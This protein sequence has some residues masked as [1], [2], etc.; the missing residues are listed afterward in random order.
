MMRFY[1]LLQRLFAVLLCACFTLTFARAEVVNIRDDAPQT[2][3]VEKGDTLWDI[4]SLFLD[5]PWRWPELWRNNTQIEN[6][7]LIYPGDMLRLRWENGVPVLELVSDKPLV[8]LSPDIKRV[9]KPGAIDILPWDKIK[10]Y[11]NNDSIMSAE[12]FHALPSILGDREGSARFV[13]D[14]YVLA[15]AKESFEI[16]S[17]T[18]YEIVRKEREIYDSLGALLGIQVIQLSEADLSNKIDT[19]RHVVKVSKNLREAKQGDRLRP[20]MDFNANDL[21]LQP[22]TRQKGELV[23]NI[24]GYNIISKHDVVIINI[25]GRKVKP[26]MVFGIYKQGKDVKFKEEP[27]YSMSRG[28]IADIF[29][30]PEV[31][32]QPAYKVGELVVIREFEHASY[33]WVTKATTHL[34]GG[35]IIASPRPPQ[36]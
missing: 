20:S 6:P 15:K 12:D 26:G 16:S 35:E 31:I 18:R 10:L 17:A 29:T 8:T 33:A 36:N 21:R 25:G 22:A 28:S 13:N 9:S 3:T 30:L 2:Y 19:D 4:S 5:Q 34:T 1:S 14:D 32:E 27:S 11:V 7:H 24:N 23:S